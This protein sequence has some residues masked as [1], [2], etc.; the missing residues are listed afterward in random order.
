MARTRR[1]QFRG[2]Y[3]NLE[4]GRFYTYMELSAV[5]GNTYNCIKSRLYNKRYV[6][7]QDLYS[8]SSQ[9]YG[10]RQPN[11]RREEDIFRLEDRSMIIMDKYL[12]RK[13]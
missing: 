2:T 11:K 12:R 7:P 9:K 3:P 13:L 5:S 6:Q 10:R 1:L 8:S 4:N